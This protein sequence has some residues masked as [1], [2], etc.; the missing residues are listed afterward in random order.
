MSNPRVLLKAK[1]ARPFFGMHPWVYA[2]AIES[3]EGEP[4]DGDAVD[5]VSHVGTFVARGLYNS[6]SKIRVRLYSWDAEQPLDGDFFQRQLVSAIR[7]RRDILRLPAAC[8][9]VFS[10]A[11]GLSGLVVDE[12]PHPQPLSQGERG[13]GGWLQVQL[14]RLAP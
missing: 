9:L 13:G 7:L 1:R 12:F 14:P 4:K 3:V 6:Q 11:D 5:L 8:R 2:G 10:E